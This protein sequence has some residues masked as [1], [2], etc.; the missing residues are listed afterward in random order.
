MAAKIVRQLALGP[1]PARR[2]GERQNMGDEAQAAGGSEARRQ[3]RALL[4]TYLFQPDFYTPEMTSRGRLV[5]EVFDCQGEE[6]P[7]EYLET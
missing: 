7:S 1:T 3:A 6:F 2:S 5:A 4:V